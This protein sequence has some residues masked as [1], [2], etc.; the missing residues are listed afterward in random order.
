MVYGNFFRKP[1]SFFSKAFYGQI[2]N[3]FPL[4]FILHRNKRLQMPK[5]F[6][7]KHFQPKQ[8]EPQFQFFLG[9]AILFKLFNLILIKRK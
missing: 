7:G 9:F 5:M 3:L 8:T 1:F 6:Y 4:T 2:T